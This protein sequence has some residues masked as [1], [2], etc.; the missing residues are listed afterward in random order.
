MA[1]LR[2]SY[3]VSRK[4]TALVCG[5][6]CGKSDYFLSPC[7]APLITTATGSCLCYLPDL[8]PQ[9]PSDTSQLPA[10]PQTSAP[11]IH[12][13]NQQ[14]TRLG[15]TLL[16]TEWFTL[17]CT[18]LTMKFILSCANTAPSMQC[19]PWLR[20]KGR[21]QPSLVNVKPPICGLTMQ[22]LST[23]GAASLIT[24]IFITFSQ[25]H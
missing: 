4:A 6:D 10:P 16:H 23:Q 12:C 25:N 21:K 19:S 14:R 5:E 17:P 18:T 22:N 7:P 20:K 9:R 15:L 1:L 24:C 8:C 11:G 3:P 13:P 2:A